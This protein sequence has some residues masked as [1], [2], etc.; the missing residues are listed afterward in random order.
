MNRTQ[1]TALA[2]GGVALGASLIA[3][4]L[5]AARRIDFSGRTVLITGGSRGLGL[6][7][8]RELGGQ[9]ARLVLGARDRAELERARQE[10]AERGVDVVT[11]EC[12]VSNRDDAERLVRTAAE[13]TGR[14]DV[15]VNNAGVIQVGPL[16]HMKLADF[17]EAMAVHFWGAL[18][19]TLAALPA[20][21]SQGEGRIVNISSIGGKIGVPH[22]V[23]YC[24]S[25]FAL[26]GLSQAMRA[27][28]APEGI[29]VTNVCPGLMRS[30]S[31]FNARFK[32]Q[33]RAE[34]TWFAISDSL[35]VATIGAARAASQ[36][37]DACRHGDAELVISWPAKLAAVANALVPEGVSLAMSFANQLLPGAT[38]GGDEA[39]S[40]WQS[41]SPWAPSTLTHLTEKAASENNEIGDHRHG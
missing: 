10:L 11:V 38:D 26:T 27:E 39:H 13:R 25:K 20:M 23:P 14:V 21:R 28:L 8:A 29:F 17:E 3:R 4:G 6:V 31:P 22:L 34:F 15:L 1:Q 40:G 16:D 7:I 35:P 30:G 37:V 19:T 32:G 9:G 24:A 41:A 2:V 18:Y 12:D 5:R 33:Y 36:V